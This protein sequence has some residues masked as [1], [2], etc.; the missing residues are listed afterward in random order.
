LRW[1]FQSSGLSKAAA[2]FNRETI[3]NRG[4]RRSSLSKEREPQRDGAWCKKKFIF[5]SLQSLQ[6]LPRG[7]APWSHPAPPRKA[8]LAGTCENIHHLLWTRWAMKPD[9]PE[10]LL[11]TLA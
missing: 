5:L 10:S 2:G 3:L 7:V 11:P 4:L 8:L 6:F 1:E 9:K